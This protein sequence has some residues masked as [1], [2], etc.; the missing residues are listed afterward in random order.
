[1]SKFEPPPLVP[2][3]SRVNQLIGWKPKHDLNAIIDQVTSH[4]KQETARA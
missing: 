2:D 3:L 4:L 1:V